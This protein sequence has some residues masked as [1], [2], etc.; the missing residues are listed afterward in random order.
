MLVQLSIVALVFVVSYLG[1]HA[2][3]LPLAGPVTVAVCGL[4]A[5]ALVRRNGESWTA[6]GIRRPRSTSSLLLTGFGYAVLGYA[7]AI[8]ATL[9]ATQLFGWPPMRT[10]RFDG[11]AG[12]LPMLFGLLAVV[13]TAAALGEEWLFRGFLQS[14]LRRLF[15]GR[16]GAAV[17]AVALQ[18]LLFALAHAYQ[19]PTGMLVTGCLGLVFGALIVRGGSLWPLVVA[20]GLIDTVSLLGLYA[21][22]RPG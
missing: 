14:R 8:A 1:L 20:H 6:A 9:L 21:G 19:G 13:W 22:M 4:L 18:A 15:D 7:T 12:N 17:M 16:R 2:I 11:L 5:A 3:G 10:A